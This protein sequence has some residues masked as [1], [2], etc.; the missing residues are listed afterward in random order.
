M[1]PSTEERF[2]VKVDRTQDC[3]IWLGLR[4]KNSRYGKFWANGKMMPTHRY[5]YEQSNGPIPVGLEID[6]LCRRPECIRPD[7]LEAVT[8]RENNKRSKSITSLNSVKTHC[9]RGHIFDLFNTRV[10]LYGK[11][12]CRTC[13]RLWY[14]TKKGHT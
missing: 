12:V 14:H 5:S 1:R 9:L 10:D 3:W 8:H 13:K 11:R 4:K 7:H 6:H 2:W